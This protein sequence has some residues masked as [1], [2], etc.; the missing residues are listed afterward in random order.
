MLC[1]YQLTIVRG[2]AV[3]RIQ[4]VDVLTRI[5]K[6][7]MKFAVI[8]LANKR[9]AL[10]C[11]CVSVFQVEP[12]LPYEYTCEGML[13]RVHSYIQHQVSSRAKHHQWPRVCI[14]RLTI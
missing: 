5:I 2:E 11:V 10:Q 1:K 8:R 4:T 12:Y 9:G 14:Y 3:R 7:E 6:G 13:E